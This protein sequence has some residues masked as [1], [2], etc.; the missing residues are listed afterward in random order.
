MFDVPGQPLRVTFIGDTLNNHNTIQYMYRTHA[1]QR[2]GV[3]HDYP[4]RY[5]ELEILLQGSNRTMQAWLTYAE[6]ICRL[7][8]L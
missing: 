1:A 2:S 5:Q 8:I 6:R 4:V 7:V 3:F